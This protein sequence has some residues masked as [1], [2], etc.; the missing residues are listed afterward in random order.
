MG[1]CACLALV[2]ICTPSH[3]R[4]YAIKFF[5]GMWTR[6]P[7]IPKNIKSLIPKQTPTWGA[8]RGNENAAKATWLGY[9]TSENGPLM[10][11]PTGC[12]L[13]VTLATLSNYPL[14]LVLRAASGSFLTL[15]FPSVV[16]RPVS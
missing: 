14:L 15:Y 11:I 5:I 8:Q 12:V 7:R 1:L 13:T 16:L 2:L 9:V 6:S 4:H 3:K 10:L